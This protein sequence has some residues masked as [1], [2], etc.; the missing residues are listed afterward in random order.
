M[1]QPDAKLAEIIAQ[2]QMQL[3]E[4]DEQLKSQLSA[5][6]QLLARKDRALALAEVKIKL[7]EERL[8]L[9]RIARYGKRSETLSDLQLQLLDLEPG[10]SSEEVEAESESEPLKAQT[11]QDKSPST[12]RR[13]HPGRQELP[14]HLERI[15]QIVRCTPEQCNCG[16]CG[17]Q[18]TVI[19]YEETEVL[20]V[21]PAEYY[22]KVIRREKR[23]CRDCE[24]QGVETAPVPERIVAKSV[25]SDQV[26]IEATVN[27]Y[28]A[29]L[30][31]YRQQ[32]MIKRDAGVEIALSTL[33]DGVLRV[34]ELLIPISAAMKREVLGETYIQADETPV[35]V[36]TH[37]KRGRNHQGYMWQYGSP[38]KGVV[39]DFRMG[40]DGEGPRQFLGNFNGLL[41][42]DGYKGYNH[43]GGPKMVHVCCLAHARRKYV[44]AVKVNANDQ[45][46]ARIVALMDQLFAID[47]E[48]RE[49]NLDHAERNLLRQERA[50]K[51]LEQLRGAA[52]AL[53]K[54]ALPK[55]AAGQA[56]NY[57]LSFWS[58]LTVFLKHPELELS[59]NLAE[60]SMRPIAIGRKNWLHLGSKEAGPK[61][62]AIF[63]VVES[64]RRLNIPIRK[65]L[66]NVL[67][68]LANRSIQSLADLTP[69]A[70]AARLA[71]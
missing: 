54:T 70:Y 13:K 34:G 24:E 27:K 42:T 55:S 56:A 21:R 48:A 15:D 25:L 39:F 58:K 45:E 61:I 7:L 63:S 1:P 41:Q 68:G 29:S 16:K 40:R 26:I 10:V 65:Y 60:N 4:K 32:A 53:K 62:A 43:V 14:S 57:T 20:D 49:Q 64:C 47:R 67:P 52:L 66:A 46:S 11:P 18:T 31:L 12:P 2:L 17:K 23:A 9:E 19:G 50:P 5:K 38:G 22:V 71:N 35:G 37:D 51:L 33:N 59:T 36:Q 69:V 8:R 44:D 3:A 30:P 28:C 6:D